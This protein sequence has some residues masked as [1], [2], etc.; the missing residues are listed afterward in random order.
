MVFPIS[1]FSIDNQWTLICV[2][3]FLIFLLLYWQRKGY[4]FLSVFSQ[5]FRLSFA[6]FCHMF[7]Y[8]LVVIIWP[9]VE[10]HWILNC[11]LNWRYLVKPHSI[12]LYNDNGSNFFI[13]FADTMEYP[14]MELIIIIIINNIIK[15]CGITMNIFGI[16]FLIIITIIIIIIITV[17]IA[18]I[19]TFINIMKAFLAGVA[20]VF[21]QLHD[22]ISSSVNGNIS[23]LS[24][25][26]IAVTCFL[27]S[28]VV[29]CCIVYS[30]VF[31]VEDFFRI[32][33]T[34]MKFFKQWFY[35]CGEWSL[36]RFII[37]IIFQD[38]F[39]FVM[40]YHVTIIMIYAYYFPWFTFSLCSE[41][42]QVIHTVV[43]RIRSQVISRNNL[44]E[45]STAR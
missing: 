33:I 13:I 2:N 31:I 39:I 6:F 15:I 34:C 37:L 28:A 43:V 20:N 24:Y 18:I 4:V 45:L 40:H 26:T 22:S 27:K 11:N 23:F 44:D 30:F 12:W 14:T 21:I 7:D 25:V 16:R 5:T 17:I 29:T 32:V 10:S 19:I 8:K 1:C 42:I 38:V 35:V 9:I 36:S 3:G 41:W